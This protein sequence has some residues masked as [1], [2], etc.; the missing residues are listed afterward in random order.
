MQSPQIDLE[1]VPGY[2][3]GYGVFIEPFGELTL[4][5]HGGN[6]WGWGAY[7]VWE[8]E[9][10]FAVAVLA[11]TFE[12]L[13]AAA[14]CIADYA[15]AQGS[16][17]PPPDPS[18]PAA[19]SRFEG[20]WDF[21][22]RTSYPL[23]GEITVEDDDELSLFLW[24]AH[25]GWTAAFTLEHAGY[26]IFLADLD[27]DGIPESDFEFLDRGFPEQV[28]WLRNRGLVGGRQSTPRPAGGSLTP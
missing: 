16:T 2:S 28:N 26:G 1:L 10:G 22:T 7:L 19:W 17:P 25:S 27:E 13:P 8:A 5:Q 12:S 15:L 14:Y 21:T 20:V 4:R 24:D 9:H 23:E 6:I 3:Y 18:D 11:N